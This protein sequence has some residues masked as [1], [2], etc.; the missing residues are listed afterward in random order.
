MLPD[1]RGGASVLVVAGLVPIA[2]V[3]ALLVVALGQLAVARAG[4]QGAADAA[5]LAAAPV[6]F[7]PFGTGGD[8][9][10]EAREAATA[11]GVDLVACTC[12]IDRTWATRVVVVRVAATIAV[13][14]NFPVTVT[15]AAAAEFAPVALLGSGP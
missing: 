11:N 8:P 4:A 2:V 14:G 12:P 9:R 13:L 1:D 5:A 10:V 15:A 7:H 3:G 6:T